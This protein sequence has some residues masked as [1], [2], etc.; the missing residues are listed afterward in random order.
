ML[1]A[2][3]SYGIIFFDNRSQTWF[4]WLLTE[5][6]LISEFF[7]RTGSTRSQHRDIGW[8]PGMLSQARGEGPREADE[9]LPRVRA[10]RGAHTGIFLYVQHCILP[11]KISVGLAPEITAPG[12]THL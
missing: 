9:P 2:Y 7:Q 6:G 4:Q 10:E 11:L 8:A 12:S 1:S 5:M 3:L